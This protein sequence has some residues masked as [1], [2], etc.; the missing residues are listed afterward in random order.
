MRL[1]AR[2]D[3]ADRCRRGNGLLRRMPCA[4]MGRTYGAA[5]DIGEL[6]EIV[7]DGLVEGVV[8]EVDGKMT[9][10]CTAEDGVG[11]GASK[12]FACVFQ[13]VGDSVE[14]S[15]EAPSLFVGADGG[16]A[17]CNESFGLVSA[18]GLVDGIMD[19][20]ASATCFRSSDVWGEDSRCN[21]Q[22]DAV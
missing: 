16:I 14:M 4:P 9:G 13:V 7:K 15:R 19:N 5:C 22:T 12:T 10:G 1:G 20:I 17:V 3:A 8:M 6:P 18:G 21:V 2:G 11:G